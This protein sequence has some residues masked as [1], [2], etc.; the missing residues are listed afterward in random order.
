ME[1]IFLQWLRH[2]KALFGLV[3]SFAATILTIITVIEFADLV[4]R[5]W[6]FYSI[7][8]A[9]IFYI[10]FTLYVRSVTYGK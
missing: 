4:K 9:V 7:F 2:N 8:T 10:L 3:I 6:W 1:Q 5:D